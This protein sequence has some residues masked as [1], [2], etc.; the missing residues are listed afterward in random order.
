MPNRGDPDWEEYRHCTR[1]RRFQDEPTS[2]D[3][4]PGWMRHYRCKFCEGWHLTS[5]PR[6]GK[7]KHEQAARNVARP[8]TIGIRT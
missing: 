1:K 3:Y 7:H 6:T 4:L 8:Q 2:A 5:K